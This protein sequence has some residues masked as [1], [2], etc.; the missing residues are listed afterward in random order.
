MIHFQNSSGITMTRIE[1]RLQDISGRRREREGR[2]Y[3]SGWSGL[4]GRISKPTTDDRE[5]LKRTLSLHF[6]ESQE[7]KFSVE[8]TIEGKVVDP[9]KLIS[10]FIR[11]VALTVQKDNKLQ[12]FRTYTTLPVEQAT[13]LREDGITFTYFNG[14]LDP[15][16]NHACL[17]IAEDTED[18]ICVFIPLNKIGSG[19]DCISWARGDKCRTTCRFDHRLDRFDTCDPKKAAKRLPGDVQVDD[20][21]KFSELKGQRLKWEWQ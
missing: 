8:G 14:K 20:E 16:I 7:S 18:K 13:T 1:S 11:H 17:R 19:Q 2:F 5:Q 4:S 12:K 3:T 10:R 15:I 21:S 9:H 6:S